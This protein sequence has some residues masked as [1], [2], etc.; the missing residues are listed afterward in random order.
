M[1]LQGFGLFIREFHAVPGKAALVE[2]VHEG[3]RIVLLHVEDASA[4][5]FARKDHFRADHG[6]NPRGVGDGLGSNFFKAFFMVADVVDVHG[7][8]L[9]VLGSGDD[10]ADAGFSFRGLAQVPRV[11]QHSLEELKRNDFHSIVH[12]RVNPG[13]AH[14]LEHFQVLEVVRGE[15]HP[16]LGPADGGDVLDQAFH[17][18]MVHAVDFIGAH[19]LR[20]GEAPVHAHGGGF[21]E[22]AVF[23]VAAGGSH[24]PDVDFR[25]EVGGEGLAVIAAVDVNDVQRMDFVKVVLERP[26]RED[27]GDAGVK[28]GAQQGKESGLAEFVLVRPLPGVFE[29][30]YVPGFIVGGVQVVNAG[31]QA[32]VH[33]VQILVGKGHVDQQLRLDFPDEGHGGGHVVRVHGVGGDIDARSGAYIVRNGVTFAFRAGGQMNVL[34]DVRQLGAFVGYHMSDAACSND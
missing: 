34:K 1:D 7:L 30:G 12:D 13:H 28:A 19:F 14:V 17:F 25:V 8:E 27:V 5:P 15:G 31:F 6:R 26:C 20:A 2:F 21:S 22:G 11:R 24:F 9:A 23:P 29:F 18:F 3:V 16:E 10:V 33:Q 32:G 4:G